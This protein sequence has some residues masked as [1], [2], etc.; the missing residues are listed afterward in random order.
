[1]S[2][3][4][5]R[6]ATNHLAQVDMAWGRTKSSRGSWNPPPQPCFYLD[7]LLSDLPCLVDVQRYLGVPH[8][9]VQR[10]ALA[11]TVE[12]RGVGKRPEAAIG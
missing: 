3:L 4:G 7:D 6:G 5:D 12:G 10:P 2:Q 9:G 11:E 1:M 8:E